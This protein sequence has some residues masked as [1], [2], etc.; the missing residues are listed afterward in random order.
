MAGIRSKMTEPGDEGA[1]TP[2]LAR[3]PA[4]R[5][6]SGLAVIS[7]L[8]LG[9]AIAANAVFQAGRPKSPAADSTSVAPDTK[10]VAQRSTSA[11]EKNTKKNLFIQYRAKTDCTIYL[12]LPGR[13]VQANDQLVWKVP[14]GQL[15]VWRYNADQAWAMVSRPGRENRHEYP[16]WGFTQRSCIGPS[17]RQR[18]V[19]DKH[20]NTVKWYPAGRS[21]PSRILE[22]RSN[23]PGGWRPVRF[24]QPAAPVVKNR[25][26]TCRNATLRDDANFV[27]GNVPQ[28]WRVH[29]TSEHRTGNHWVKVQVPNNANRWG[30]IE[31][32]AVTCK[33]SAAAAREKPDTPAP[34]PVN[35]PAAPAP[36]T[37]AP[38]A[39]EA[40]PPEPAPTNGTMCHWKVIWPAAGVYDDPTRSQPPLKSKHS[41]DIVGPYCTTQYNAA[42]N[43]TY[44]Q[45]QTDSAAD[46]I[47][48]MRLPALKQ[49]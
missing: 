5:I 42:E 44:V 12:N 24:D 3:R 31:T 7:A 47:G 34:P 37:T 11:L 8:T 2:A 21:I 30:Y 15:L 48:W 28:G 16:W 49:V 38:T 22:G 39:P 25:V 6:V 43:E 17:I 29:V 20:E 33:A 4:V 10:N 32:K 23:K 1:R 19:S 18:A 27:I 45:V 46:G 13:G 40:A 36:P 9:S 35:A 26:R 14:R 41:G